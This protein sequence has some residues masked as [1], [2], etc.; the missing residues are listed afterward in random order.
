MAIV[1]EGAEIGRRAWARADLGRAK[2]DGNSGA[3][4]WAKLGSPMTQR[5]G[6]SLPHMDRLCPITRLPNYSNGSA[7]SQS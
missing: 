5:H 4:N 1:R 7:H 3:R 2:L 6:S